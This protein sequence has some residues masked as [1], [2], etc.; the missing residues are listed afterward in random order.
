MD[1]RDVRE[2]VCGGRIDVP[3]MSTSTLTG[4][5]AAWVVLLLTFSVLPFSSFELRLNLICMDVIVAEYKT[6]T[7][8]VRVGDQ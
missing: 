8:T 4:S 3:V 2:A 1:V 7:R 6:S 5:I